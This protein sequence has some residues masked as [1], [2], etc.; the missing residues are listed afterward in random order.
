MHDDGS[1]EP[2]DELAGDDGKDDDMTN[3][4]HSAHAHMHS[5]PHNPHQMGQPL[6]GQ[7]PAHHRFSMVQGHAL[8]FVNAFCHHM[9]HCWQ[10]ASVQNSSIHAGV[11][12]HMISRLLLIAPVIAA[13]GISLCLQA[14]PLYGI[15]AD[16]LSSG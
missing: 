8:H 10:C 6:P 11:L 1:M 4:F 3:V 5:I 13:M 16:A 12:Q 7:P 2:D 9:H 15:L 14:L